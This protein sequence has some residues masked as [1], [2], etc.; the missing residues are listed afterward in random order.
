MERTPVNT[1]ALPD[2]CILVR[3]FVF[4]SFPWAAG[5][6]LRDGIHSMW[7]IVRHDGHHLTDIRGRSIDYPWT[8]CPEAT[9]ML[10]ALIGADIQAERA[11]SV[12]QS[13]QCTHL[14]DLARLTI[15]HIGRRERLHYRFTVEWDDRDGQELLAARAER[16]GTTVL[17]WLLSDYVVQHP[18]SFAGHRVDG[19]AILPASC[20]SDRDTL[21]AAMLL[22]RAVKTFRGRDRAAKMAQDIAP[23]DRGWMANACYTFR[24]ENAPRAEHSPFPVQDSLIQT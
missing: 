11:S 15:G 23:A 22:R 3:D 7:V 24:P 19:R 8:T 14:L 18:P 1:A 16:N 17:C 20:R 12:D 21:E 2:D 9:H 6:R 10:D 5:A 13:A 4:R